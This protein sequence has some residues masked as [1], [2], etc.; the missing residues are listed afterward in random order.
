MKQ[1]VSEFTAIS[2]LLRRTDAQ[3]AEEMAKV[4]DF[5]RLATHLS[6]Y[7]DASIGRIINGLPP[8]NRNLVKRLTYELKNPYTKWSDNLQK[9]NSRYGRYTYH[10]SQINL[11]KFLPSL[12]LG[13][14]LLAISGYMI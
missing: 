3:I 7:D 2:G 8:E 10:S 12:L 6:L 9:N 14:I 1:Q 11:N 4:R 5:R 13:I